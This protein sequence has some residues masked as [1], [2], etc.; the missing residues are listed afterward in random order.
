ARPEWH[1]YWRERELTP[2]EYHE[3]Y[4]ARHD[5]WDDDYREI[6][7]TLPASPRT[8]PARTAAAA[9]KGGC[10]SAVALVGGFL[11]AA[12]ELVRQVVV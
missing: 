4:V 3:M 8:Q 11:T 2:A 7:I 5:D 9:K 6:R 1:E 12:A 10:L